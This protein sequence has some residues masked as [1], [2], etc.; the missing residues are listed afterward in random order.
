MPT[1]HSTASHARGQLGARVNLSRFVRQ[2][3]DQTT[4]EVGFGWIGTPEAPATY[5]QLRAAFQHSVKSGDPL[6]V[7]NQYC[8]D[9]VFVEPSDN[10]AFRY[11]HDVSHCRLG[12]S[13]ALPDE[14]EL[15]LWHLDQLA[16]AGYPPPTLEYQ[17]L[18][19]DLLGQIILLGIAGRF[20]FNQGEFTR[21][22][23][24]LGLDAGVMSEL[25]RIS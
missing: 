19:L 17:L 11:W 14:W 15:T 7:S 16:A 5:P 3:A 13:F 2:Q 6:P 25:R 21:T 23:H 1:H 12:L 18:R 8:D 9:T 10:V 22:C 24:E 4:E 20:P